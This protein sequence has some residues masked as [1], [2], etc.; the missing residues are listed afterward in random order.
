[1]VLTGKLIIVESEQWAEFQKLHPRQASAMIRDYVSSSIGVAKGDLSGINIKILQKD[2]E[3]KEILLNETQAELTDLR[4][5]MD[6][7][8][9]LKEKEQRDKLE[10]KKLALEREE[11][12]TKCKGCL[13]ELT[14]NIEFRGKVYQLCVNCLRAS[15]IDLSDEFL[16]GSETE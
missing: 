9:Q 5:K 15:I 13:C 10:R 8:T 6:K 14:S 11:S 1:M 16:A 4:L 7:Y 3:H 12:R 2:I